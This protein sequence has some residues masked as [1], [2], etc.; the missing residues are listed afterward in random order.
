MNLITKKELAQAL[1]LSR[2]WADICDGYA[3]EIRSEKKRYKKLLFNADDIPEI[4]K[5]LESLGRQPRN[6]TKHTAEHLAYL[7]EKYTNGVPAG[8]VE[9]WIL[10][11]E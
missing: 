7:K 2:I 9:K 5:A 11:G 3:V 6:K 8:E 10:R 1:G 4:K